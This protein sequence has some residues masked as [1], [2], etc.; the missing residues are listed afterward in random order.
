MSDMTVE[1]RHARLP[2]LPISFFAVVMGLSGLTLATRAA[3]HALHLGPVA[4]PWL[5]LASAIAFGLIALLYLSKAALHWEAVVAEWRHPVRIAFFPAISIS[6]LLI[7]T[8][9]APLYPAE[10]EALWLAGTL[11]QGAL[12]LAVV[13]SWIGHRPFQ[14]LHLSP[15]WFIP[16]VGNVIVPVAGAGFGYVELSWLFFSVGVVFWIVLL[17]LVFNRLVFHDP[18]PGRLTPTLVIL[19]A[20][21]AV[22]FIAYLRLGEER[23]PVR[24]HPAERRL[25]VPRRGRDA[26]RQ[27]REAALRAV[28][29]GAELPHRGAD[30]RVLPL[31]R[32]RRLARARGVRRRA[33]GASG[34]HRRRA[35]AAHGGGGGAPRDL[36]AGI[37]GEGLG[38]DAVARLPQTPP[39]QCPPNTRVWKGSSSAS[40]RSRIACTIATVSM[41]CSPMACR[42]VARSA[43]SVP[44]KRE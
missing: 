2:E 10:A 15:A 35:G 43:A 16:A 34:G 1:A 25:S 26:G 18:L 20:P 22:A 38:G 9:A 33:L 44:W 8:A 37:G 5:L 19:I 30:H 32:S 3:E 39:P 21:P 36:P 17:T 27:D 24:A 14:H 12:T 6:M 13:A 42:P 23:R 31:R 29:L 28:F 11:T 7:A 40:I 41:M 4:S